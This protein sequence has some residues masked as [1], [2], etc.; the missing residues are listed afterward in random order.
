[1]NK[2]RIII[3]IIASIIAGGITFFLGCFLF[4]SFPVMNDGTEVSFNGIDG[5]IVAVIFALIA[6]VWIFIILN[7][8]WV[9]IWANTA[10]MDKTS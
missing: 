10:Q 5:L 1:M 7:D 3:A 8:K 4:L 2:L 6:A 9:H